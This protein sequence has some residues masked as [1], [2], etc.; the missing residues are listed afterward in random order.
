MREEITN[1]VCFL[2]VEYQ[3]HLTDISKIAIED[4]DVAVYEFECDELVVLLSYLTYEEEG[5]IAAVYDLPAF[6]FEEITHARPSVE[7]Q[8]RDVLDDFC[9]GFG[10]QGDEPFCE[11]EL[12]LPR[13]KEDIVYC[14]FLAPRA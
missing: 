5:G 3:V 10:G 7:R 12:A 4:L 8:L 11:T 2:K 1:G 13:H 9:L 14:H 6:I